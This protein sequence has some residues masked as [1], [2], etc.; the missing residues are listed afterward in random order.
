MYYDLTGHEYEAHHN[1]NGGDGADGSDN[2]R[3]WGGMDGGSHNG[4]KFNSEKTG[5]GSG[6]GDNKPSQ[7]GG[8]S[9]YSGKLEQVSKPDPAADAL[10]ERINGQSRVKFS[11]NPDGR[12]FDTISDEY[13][14]QAKPAL[15]T[16]NKSVRNQM[17][18]IF[19]AALANGK[20]ILS[21]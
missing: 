4:K 16:V 11:N 7:G 6:N 2:S 8:S 20:S 15:E 3:T 10:D 5:G 12:E 18:A 19:E 17:K 14:A 1:S 13:I 21:I 9:K